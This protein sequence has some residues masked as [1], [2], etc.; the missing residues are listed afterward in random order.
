MQYRF[1]I[2]ANDLSN[3][4]RAV[5]FCLIFA[6]PSWS[7]AGMSA[8]PDLS[9]IDQDISPCQD[10]YQYACGNWIKGNPIPP[11][12]AFWARYS[13]FVSENDFLLR[14]IMENAARK[15]HD[16]SHTEQIV[17]DYYGSCMDETILRKQGVAPLRAKLQTIGSTS[18]RSDLTRTLARLHSLG[19]QSL[20]SLGVRRGFAD[21]STLIAE[22]DAGG[23]TLPGRDYY[24][25]PTPKTSEIRKKY[26]EHLARTFQLAG[27]N[28][29]Q[30]GIEARAVLE[31]ETALARASLDTGARRDPKNLNRIKTVEELALLVP[32]IDWPEFFRGAGIPI[33][34]NL[35][36]AEPE[37]F[38]ALQSTTGRCCRSALCNQDLAVR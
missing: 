3:A 21:S 7:P 22:I 16:R 5:L 36:V 10:F 11:D 2:S 23:T 27:D 28:A 19:V 30:A 29:V 38:N 8:G 4:L 37:F 35:N 12:R 24:L 18:S 33:F 34:H 14:S 9:A 26:F 32:T 13:D 25:D 31:I 20:F 1:V 17:G 6:L 15:K